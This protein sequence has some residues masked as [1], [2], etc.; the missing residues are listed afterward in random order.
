MEQIAIKDRRGDV[1]KTFNAE[2]YKNDFQLEQAAKNYCLRTKRAK[3]L[4]FCY[5]D[6]TRIE[7]SVNDVF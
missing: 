3:N 5:S 4:V 1:I 2:D 6:K 7:E